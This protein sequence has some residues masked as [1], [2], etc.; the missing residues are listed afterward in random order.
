MLREGVCFTS[1]PDAKFKNNYLSVSFKLPL[2]RETAALY[3]LLPMVLRRGCREYPDMTSLNHRLQELYGAQLDGGVTKRGEIQIVTFYVDALDDAFALSGEAQLAACADLLCSLIFEPATENGCFRAGDVA[4]E[5]HNLCDLIDSRLNDKRYY[6]SQ[7]LKEEMCRGEAYGLSEYGT[8]ESAEAITPAALWQAWLHMLHGA[9]VE[10]FHVGPGDPAVC[11]RRL[12]TAFGSVPRGDLLACGTRVVRQ[13]G[14]VRTVTDRLPVT[15]AKLCLGFRAG[16][17]VP[18]AETPAMQLACT[19]FGGSP[20]AKLFA[21]VR[22]KMSLCYYC[23]SRYERFKG[24]LLVESG[25]EEA[26]F[27]KARDEI[28]RQL[29]ELQAGHVTQDE[30]KFA[31]LSLGNSYRELSDTAA[32]IAQWYLVQSLAGHPELSPAQAARKAETLTVKDIVQAAG[33]IRLETVYLL[34]GSAQS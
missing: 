28:L 1:I 13:A 3:A 15:Q 8:R 32:G 4:I 6:A 17:A 30:L 26:N 25:I 29:S 12:R 24:L 5:T 18:D 2:K 31:S 21:N 11:A 33:H 10:I 34:A 9:E 20:H 14:D 27:E 16:I 23:F 7:R 19:V 22:E